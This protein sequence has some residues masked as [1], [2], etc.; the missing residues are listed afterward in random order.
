MVTVDYKT[1]RKTFLVVSYVLA[2]QVRGAHAKVPSSCSNNRKIIVE[3]SCFPTSSCDK[4]LQM[5]TI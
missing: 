3:S 5:Q 4:G 1:S 2:N